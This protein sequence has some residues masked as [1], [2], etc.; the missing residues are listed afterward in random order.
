VERTLAE[1]GADLLVATLDRLARGPIT[2][3]AQDDALA[4]YAHRILKDDGIVDWDRSAVQI[5]NQVRGLHP[6][7]HAFAF[8][9]DRRLI[10]HRSEVIDEPAATPPG[11]VVAA[12]GDQLVVA[13]GSQM[14][15][16]TE[17][18]SEGSR[19]MPARAFL[20]GHAMSAGDRLTVSP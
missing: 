14:L 5:H 2:E 11:T 13:T 1:L 9:H 18:Q 12:T 7:P 19:A 16:I 10:L 20:A 17:L 4:T 3:T 8:H 15:R 6:W